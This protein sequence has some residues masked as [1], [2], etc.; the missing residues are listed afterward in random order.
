MHRV[1]LTFALENDGPVVGK[2]P[3]ITLER[4]LHHARGFTVGA[5]LI[6]AL[7]GHRR[8]TIA[9]LE[10]ILRVNILLVAEVDID[11]HHGARDVVR[12]PLHGFADDRPATVFHGDRLLGHE[13]RK[14]DDDERE[15]ATPGLVPGFN[16]VAE[17]PLVGRSLTGVGLALV[18]DS[19]LKAVANEGMHHP[20]PIHV[21]AV[22]PDRLGLR[23]SLGLS[24]AG[25]HGGIFLLLPTLGIR[26]GVVH[27]ARAPGF[28]P[29][30]A[31]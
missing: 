14:L 9:D 21:R 23:V 19:T 3:G 6:D 11:R 12:D 27:T 22:G 1:T 29:G 20:V 16:H 30:T 25:G 10:L 5:A 7:E 28:R 24:D 2:D 26:L 4:G 18:P 13:A 17:D 15:F 8:E 31:D